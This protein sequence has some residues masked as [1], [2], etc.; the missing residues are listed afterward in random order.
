MFA[1]RLANLRFS[2]PAVAES[3]DRLTKRA[4]PK[5]ITVIAG[6]RKPFIN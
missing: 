3:F 4:R 5:R 6:R 1:I 2:H